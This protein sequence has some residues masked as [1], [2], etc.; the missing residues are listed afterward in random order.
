[1]VP[2]R[3]ESVLLN[4]PLW[5]KNDKVC[6][7]HTRSVAGACEHCENRWILQ[8]GFQSVSLISYLSE[9]ALTAWS[10]ETAFTTM[11]FPRSYLYG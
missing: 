7:S 9:R 6:H 2:W 4:T 5:G 10:N 11:N 1:M 3:S 8:V